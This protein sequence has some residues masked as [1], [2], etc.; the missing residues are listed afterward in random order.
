M[1]PL[2]VFLMALKFKCDPE[3]ASQTLLDNCSQDRGRNISNVIFRL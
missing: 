3:L 1:R 2:I